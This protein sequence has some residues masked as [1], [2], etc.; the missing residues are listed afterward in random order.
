MKRPQRQSDGHLISDQDRY[1]RFRLIGWWDQEKLG[2]ASVLVAGCGALGNEVTKN[3]VLLGVGEVVVVDNDIVENANLAKSVLFR[4]GDTGR[5]KVEV[6]AERL[7]ELNPDVRIRPL[8]GDVLLDLGLGLFRDVDLAIGCLDNREARL[9]VNQ[10]CW[11]MGTPWIDGAIQEIS[12]VAKVFVPPDG[13]C[14][15]CTF[16]DLD[17]RYLNLRYSCPG[18]KSE[19][20]AQGKVPT[21]PTISSIIAGIQAQEAVKMIHGLETLASHA[22]VFNGVTNFFYVTE[23]PRREDCLSHETYPPAEE[24]GLEAH[25]ATARELMQ[26]AFGT[27]EGACV[28]LDRDFVTEI[29]CPPCSET[30]TLN[31]PRDRIAAGRGLCPS[32]GADMSPEFLQSIPAS[33]SLADRPLADLGIPQHDVVRVRR[34]TAVRYLLLA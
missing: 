11:R 26:A 27:D 31:L 8:H 23:I 12:G 5:S 24:T 7:A 33:S 9:F 28:E 20:I 6:A 14:Y 16:T 4:P 34:E 29:S 1:A 10:A 18:L 22:L 25:A 21:T 17:Y 13:S 2:S 30:R 15:E 19:D 32:C 3:L